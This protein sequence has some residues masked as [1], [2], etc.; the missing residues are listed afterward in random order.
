MS[1]ADHKVSNHEEI[2]AICKLSMHGA[3]QISIPVEIYLET[4]EIY[5]KQISVMNGLPPV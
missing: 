4:W 2:K 5:Q 3:F 1:K